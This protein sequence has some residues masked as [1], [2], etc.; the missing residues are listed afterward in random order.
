MN[1]AMAG[2][3]VETGQREL[4]IGLAEARRGSC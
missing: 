2:W 3:I 1:S 4:K